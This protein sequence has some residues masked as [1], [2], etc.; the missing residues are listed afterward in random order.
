L[1]SYIL[2][3]RADEGL[4]RDYPGYLRANRAKLRRYVMEYVVKGG[5][6]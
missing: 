5:G 2:L 3:A 1:E 4:I 6:N